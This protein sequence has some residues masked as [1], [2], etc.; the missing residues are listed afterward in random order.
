MKECNV[1]GTT[2]GTTALILMEVLAQESLLHIFL[3]SYCQRIQLSSLIYHTFLT[4]YFGKGIYSFCL[5]LPFFL[6]HF[7]I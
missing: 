5:L 1:S 6:D 7:H 2:I 3:S 4:M